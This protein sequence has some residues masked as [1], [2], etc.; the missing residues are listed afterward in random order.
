L[1]EALACCQGKLPQG[2]WH[3]AKVKSLLGGA[4]LGQKKYMDAEPLLLAGYEGLNA[5]KK[6]LP[7]RE[8]RSHTDAALRL[9]KLYDEWPKPAEAAKWRKVLEDSSP[10]DKN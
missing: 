1:R 5:G 4:L 6:D 8:Q 3:V 10:P 2:H 9:V 7:A